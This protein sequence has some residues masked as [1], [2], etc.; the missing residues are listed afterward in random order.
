[1]LRGQDNFL[2]PYSQ[3][4]LQVGGLSCRGLWED[5]GGALEVVGLLQGPGQAWVPG[6]VRV[7][8]K[9]TPL[10]NLDFGG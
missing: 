9:D 2:S 3:S 5:G 6:G 1:M 8:E 4:I 7:L 10:L